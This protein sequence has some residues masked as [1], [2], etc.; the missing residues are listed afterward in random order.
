MEHTHQY[1]YEV[2]ENG[3]YTASCTTCDYVIQVND[4]IE[5]LH[6]YYSLSGTVVTAHKNMQSVL[7]SH[8]GNDVFEWKMSTFDAELESVS[9]S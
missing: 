9:A 4:V 6:R 3:V 5:L 7:R 1:S 8:L 2:A